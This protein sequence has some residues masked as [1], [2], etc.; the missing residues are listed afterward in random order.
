[1]LIGNRGH[2]L[3]YHG[4]PLGERILE[5]QWICAAA[6]KVDNQMPYCFLGELYF[7]YKDEL[8]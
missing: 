1:M 7:V 8:I 2:E 5:L 3:V 4:I 6:A